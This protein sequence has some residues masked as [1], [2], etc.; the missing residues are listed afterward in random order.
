MV[1]KASLKHDFGLQKLVMLLQCY[2]KESG[3]LKDI[4]PV[5]IFSVRCFMIVASF[6][7]CMK[8]LSSYYINTYDL[9]YPYL[10]T[11]SSYPLG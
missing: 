1:S 11:R 6:V 4:M 8:R 10:Q 7:S 3:Y 5:K 9:E 2:P